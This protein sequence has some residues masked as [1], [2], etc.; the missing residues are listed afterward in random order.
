MAV[1]PLATLASC[2]M[3]TVYSA[4]GGVEFEADHAP[5]RSCGSTAAVSL[6]AVSV[7]LANFCHSL[8]VL[9]STGYPLSRR[10]DLVQPVCGVQRGAFSH[11]IYGLRLLIIVINQ[12]SNP[13]GRGE[14]QKLVKN[15]ARRAAEKGRR[16]KQA[17]PWDRKHM[18]REP[19]LF[20]KSPK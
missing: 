12:V 19:P 9:T 4:V 17:D 18:Y 11:Q 5:H 16:A 13:D 20:P 10:E 14:R 8:T 6:T 2:K 3:L 1:A 15:R 7:F